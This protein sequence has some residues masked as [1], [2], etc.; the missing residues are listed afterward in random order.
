MSRKVHFLVIC[1][2]DRIDDAGS[3]EALPRLPKEFADRATFTFANSLED[4]AKSPGAEKAEGVLW[5]PGGDSKLIAPLF[6]QFESLKWLHSW[7]V[8]V[9][10]V[11]PFVKETFMSRPE[12]VFTNS[13]GS[14]SRALA[15]WAI[16]SAMYFERDIPRV[17]K[18]RE[19]KKW[20]VHKMGELV[21]KTMGF[22]GFGD[23][24]KTTARIAKFG[25]EM[26][27]LALRNTKPANPVP[28]ELADDIFYSSD[29]DGKKKLFSQ[30]DFIV[31]SLP[32]TPDTEKYCGASEFAVMKPTGV[33]ISVGRGTA[34]DEEALIGVLQSGAIRGAALDV[35]YEE[36]LPKS[37]PIWDL[38]NV[39][40]TAHCADWTD[41]FTDGAMSVFGKNLDAFV[42]GKEMVTPVNVEAGY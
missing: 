24:A 22:V 35:F 32:N 15:E 20:D 34:V 31:C 39:L 11:V 27:I 19:E 26:K 21:G 1:K 37:S 10:Y 3:N 29:P 36:P 30:S 17:Q 40:L 28:D 7:A 9:N 25:F 23:I 12:L 16:L 13:R 4:F 42:N 41:S 33:F 8:G 38:S 5:I 18:G 2:Q 14:F 6:S